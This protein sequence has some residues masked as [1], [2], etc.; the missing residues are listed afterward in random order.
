MVIFSK[1][2]WVDT[3]ERALKTFAQSLLA[4]LTASNVGSLNVPWPALLSAAGL[5]ALLSVLTSV[6]GV[7]VGRQGSPSMVPVE[8][9]PAPS[10]QRT[11]AR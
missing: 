8:S 9:A 6:G 10:D 5:A 4:L 3:V 7:N 1:A 2:F 11:S